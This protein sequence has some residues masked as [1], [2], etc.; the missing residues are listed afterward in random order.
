MTW[1]VADTL[2]HKRVRV[3]VEICHLRGDNWKTCTIYW[4]HAASTPTT[5]AGEKWLMLLPAKWNKQVQYAW[6]FDPCEL[7]PPGTGRPPPH[8]PRFEY[9][10]PDDEFLDDTQPQLTE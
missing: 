2:E 3:C 10:A 5:A 9:G 1:P 6:R 7:A 8:A 4:K